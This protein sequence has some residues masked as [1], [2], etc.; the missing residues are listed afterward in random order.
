M[1]SNFRFFFLLPGLL[2]SMSSVLTACVE[3]PAAAGTQKD[4]GSTLDMTPDLAEV[5]LDMTMTDQNTSPED[6]GADA[7][8]VPDMTSPDLSDLS[9]DMSADMFQDM[10]EVGDMADM[11]DID[12]CAEQSC[13]V[14]LFCDPKT[15][16]CEQCVD[17]THC[18]TAIC[19][20]YT[21]KCEECYKMQGS[22]EAIIGCSEDRPYCSAGACVDQCKYKEGDTSSEC[23]GSTPYCNNRNR[24]VECQWN[25]A[26]TAFVGCETGETCVGGTCE[27]TCR[28]SDVGN[29][30]GCPLNLP[31][32]VNEKC[33]VCTDDN[34][35]LQAD[36]GC[37]GDY[38]SC[39]NDGCC[40]VGGGNCMD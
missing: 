6:M 21:N 9:S 3:P 7:D 35:P 10:A 32:C 12:L 5:I 4:L 31:Y 36:P 39:I 40:T 2:L 34:N 26:G 28:G 15:G 33:E 37:P 8:V 25:L 24:C 18:T 22:D 13:D 23:P 11:A 20:P 38:P 29:A 30:A 17:T 19:N 1:P 27:S 14:G 16:Q